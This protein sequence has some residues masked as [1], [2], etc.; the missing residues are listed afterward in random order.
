MIDDTQYWMNLAGPGTVFACMDSTLWRNPSSSTGWQP[1]T[2]DPKGLP[3]SQRSKGALWFM[4][5]ALM[6]S[7]TY[8]AFSQRLAAALNAQSRIVAF[9]SLPLA[10]EQWKV[11]AELLFKTSLARI[12]VEARNIAR[13]TGANYPGYAKQNRSQEFCQGVYMFRAEGWQNLN[14]WGWFVI[15]LLST[16]IIIA[17]IP[18]DDTRLLFEL[19]FIGLLKKT[20]AWIGRFGR[21]LLTLI[22]KATLAIRQWQIW[23]TIATL[24]GY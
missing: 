5:H 9:K 13:G 20:G 3:D 14:F 1:I 12:Q 7:H 6:N 8:A 10:T 17:A 11:E 2:A 18:I 4:L 23:S 22:G 15:L 19:D 21:W 16:V 24:F